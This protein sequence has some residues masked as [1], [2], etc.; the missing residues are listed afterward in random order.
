M[1]KS[2][3]DE[4]RDEFASGRALLILSTPH[5]VELNAGSGEVQSR[6]EP[7][8]CFGGVNSERVR[9]PA[10]RGMCRTF[11]M[12]PRDLA[13]ASEEAFKRKLCSFNSLT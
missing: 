2:T 10:D 9:S 1:V 7:L 6:I 13:G 5:V 4:C 12:I 3:E 8:G 11:R